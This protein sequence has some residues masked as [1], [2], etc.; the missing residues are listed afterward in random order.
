[1]SKVITKQQGLYFYLDIFPME[2]VNW[3]ILTMET[4]VP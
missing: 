3:E 2:Y 1:M 4:V